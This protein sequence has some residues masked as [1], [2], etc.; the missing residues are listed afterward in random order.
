[1]RTQQLKWFRAPGLDSESSSTTGKSDRSG[2]KTAEAIE[3]IGTRLGIASRLSVLSD[4]SQVSE[5]IVRIFGPEAS[6]SGFLCAGAAASS[7]GQFAH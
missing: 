6:L 3:E 5:N 1:M 7:A 2:G 4:A